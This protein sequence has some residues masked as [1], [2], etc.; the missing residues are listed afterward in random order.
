MQLT[1]GPF[2]TDCLCENRNTT[3]EEVFLR[4]A[5]QDHDVNTAIQEVDA[6]DT[7]R[8][9]LM[10]RPSDG[11]N[12]SAD[13]MVCVM[14]GPNADQLIA[15]S[16]EEMMIKVMDDTP[17]E[18]E[19][20]PM[21][22]QFSIGDSSDADPS[23]EGD[24]EPVSVT[25]VVNP[26]YTAGENDQSPVA[27]RAVDQVV[28][29]MWKD[30]NLAFGCRKK[31]GGCTA[32]CTFKCCELGCYIV[33][34]M[35]F[36]LAAVLNTFVESFANEE[37]GARYCA[38]GVLNATG[39]ENPAENQFDTSTWSCPPDANGV[40]A[41]FGDV[42]WGQT[43]QS[44]GMRW[45]AGGYGNGNGNGN[46]YG[47]GVQS[48]TWTPTRSGYGGSQCSDD[49]RIKVNLCEADGL[50]QM[51]VDWASPI[52]EQSSSS[53]YQCQDQC[54][55]QN[56][57]CG[58]C[59]QPNTNC[60]CCQNCDQNCQ[61]STAESSRQC[62]N[63]LKVCN[64][65]G[66]C[67][68]Q[69]GPYLANNNGNNNNQ[70][71]SP[72]NPNGFQNP[73]LNIWYSAEAEGDTD[74]ADLRLFTNRTDWYHTDRRF[75]RFG[76]AA[77]I[78]QAVRGAQRLLRD[79]SIGLHLVNRDELQAEDPNQAVHD[80]DTCPWR[81][82]HPDG[83]WSQECFEGRTLDD[84]QTAVD[85]WADTFPSFS[86]EVKEASIPVAP[87]TVSSIVLHWNLRLWSQGNGQSFRYVDISAAQW[88]VGN[89]GDT[90][91]GTCTACEQVGPKPSEPHW[92]LYGNGDTAQNLRRAI[93]EMSNVV[94]R[95]IHPVLDDCRCTNTC[96]C[97]SEQCANDS[98]DQ[99]QDPPVTLDC[100]FTPGAFC[101]A[102]HTGDCAAIGTSGANAG[103]DC[104]SDSR[105]TYNDQGTSGD[106]ADDVC[107]TATASSTCMAQAVN[108]QS[109]CNSAGNMCTGTND[110]TSTAATCTGA[111]DGTGTACVLNGDSSACAVE[112]V[113]EF[114]ASTGA[115]C[116][117]N[118]DASAC[119]VNGGDCVFAD[120]WGAC[121]Y[122]DA[123]QTCGASVATP[124]GA[125]PAGCNY[126]AGDSCTPPWHTDGP[127]VN[128]NYI[129]GDPASCG[130]GCTYRAAE[131]CVPAWMDCSHTPGN[132]ASCR[133]GCTYTP[134]FVPDGFDN[135]RD[136]EFRLD[137]TF[138]PMPELE[139]AKREIQEIPSFWLIMVPMLT[140]LLLPALSSMLAME[141]EEGLMEMVKTEGGRVDAYFL[142]N[143]L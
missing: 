7:A 78:D 79:Q 108:G 134:A 47:D 135:N 133:A 59:S 95:S 23:V 33:I 46:G 61:Q 128:C 106:T 132:A 85:W 87:Q 81:G 20:Q 40:G 22:E 4:L 9:M 8:V 42:C 118:G 114:T 11:S 99:P 6:T 5:A 126:N 50:G 70:R 31:G 36:G 41:Q 21:M 56:S 102:T 117:L 29:V 112:G 28:A 105:C 94:L 14:E 15:V 96:N 101:T 76:S 49:E 24:A 55:Q 60:Q 139:F 72:D 57:M 75:Q 17:E 89:W 125:A 130:A 53:L 142:G 54:Q 18:E 110:G 83:R 115:A 45:G 2:L 3:L 88:A 39:W 136:C 51:L 113:C 127:G 124:A 107:E 63:N 73:E 77:E 104:T 93:N 30:T 92:P 32:C 71:P 100:S 16:P 35:V 138:V 66:S 25:A 90:A 97:G 91:E 131:S 43:V 13:D 74:L 48:G 62:A 10:R 84:S 122:S 109:A 120:A 26:F 116:A 123:Q 1:Y 80:P 143:Y 121:T 37:F 65:Y 82:Y 34:F 12:P 52:A 64:N 119:A 103:D 38:N 67:F 98:C 68:D 86:I 137:T 69:M 140:M 44:P 141:K 27:V 58:C 19:V 111:D 129:P